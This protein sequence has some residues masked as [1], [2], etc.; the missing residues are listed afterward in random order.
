M[1]KKKTSGQI[2]AARR[3]SGKRAA[4]KAGQPKISLVAKAYRPGPR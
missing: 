3:R 2:S 1:I 4:K